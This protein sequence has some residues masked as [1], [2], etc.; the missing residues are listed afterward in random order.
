VAI[1]K[2]HAQIPGTYF[3]TSSTYGRRAVFQVIRHC[4]MFVEH[5]QRYRSEGI[6]LLHGFV[7]MRDHF[8]LVLTPSTETSLERAVQF[9]KGGTSHAIGVLASRNA[10]IWQRGFSD[11]RIRDLNDFGIHI[12]YINMNPVRR[13][14][15]D[16]PERFRWCS[17]SGLYKMDAV[18]QR[19]KPSVGDDLQHG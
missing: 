3:V 2:R 13:G 18:P 10:P 1:P 11:H 8:H 14:L 19:L 12:N 4:E 5:L 17:A 15:V 6:F 7:L 16:S 9:I